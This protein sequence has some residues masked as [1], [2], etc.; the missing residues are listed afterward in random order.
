MFYIQGVEAAQEKMY[1]ALCMRFDVFHPFLFVLNSYPHLSHLNFIRYE[2]PVSTVC[3]YNLQVIL[4]ITVY[5]FLHCVLLIVRNRQYVKTIII[6][7]GIC[8]EY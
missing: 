8:V 3:S 4:Q 1:L 5:C 7:L 6:I 2:A